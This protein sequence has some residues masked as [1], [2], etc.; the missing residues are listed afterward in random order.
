MRQELIKTIETVVIIS[1]LAFTSNSAVTFTEDWESGSIDPVKW[2]AQGSSTPLIL[3]SDGN[4]AL[5]L[6]NPSLN[7]ADVA[8]PGPVTQ[9]GRVQKPYRVPSW[10]KWWLLGSIVIAIVGWPLSGLVARKRR[11]QLVPRQHL[12]KA[13][14]GDASALKAI[15][16]SSRAR[17]ADTRSKLARPLARELEEQARLTVPQHKNKEEEKGGA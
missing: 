4:K 16:E 10:S 3:D 13:L 15:V 5:Y 17:S 1:L 6:Q 14:R 8:S 9:Q 11:R 12:R 2:T 7:W